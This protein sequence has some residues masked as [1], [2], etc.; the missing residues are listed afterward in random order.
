[1]MDN[2]DANS[3]STFQDGSG[4]QLHVIKVY[5]LD[6]KP[7]A[8][9]QFW[10]AVT[11]VQGELAKR[12]FLRDGQKHRLISA[13][14][15]LCLLPSENKKDLS[16]ILKLVSN[17]G[18]SAPAITN[19]SIA[20]IQNYTTSLNEN[21]AIKQNS[22]IQQNY[23]VV[24]DGIHLGSA[25]KNAA[26][27]DKGYVLNT[28]SNSGI[29][30][31]SL[32]QTAQLRSWGAIKVTGTDFFRRQVWLV[33]AARGMYI[34]GY[35]HTEEDRQALFKR[36]PVSRHANIRSEYKPVQIDKRNFIKAGVAL[37]T[38]EATID[39]TELSQDEL[40]YLLMRVHQNDINNQN[41]NVIDIVLNNNIDIIQ[42][43]INIDASS[44][45]IGKKVSDQVQQNG[46]ALTDEFE[47]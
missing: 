18:G 30:I 24:A 46:A 37:A 6:G 35:M 39:L 10:V 32:V 33:A 31:E 34:E 11:Q 47:L 29:V 5:P 22:A 42:N 14:A 4:Q 1:M 38:N 44:V 7:I 20:H 23:D 27:E 36:I 41:S 16:A 8:E 43:L 13:Q 26:F 28:T 9:S 3:A 25:A 45:Q 40:T 2:S 21:K 12:L 17:K 19:N 15:A